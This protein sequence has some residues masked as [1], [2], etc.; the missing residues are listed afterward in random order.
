MKPLAIAGVVLIGLGLA[1][2]ILQSI[3]LTGSETIA[4]V[5]PLELERETEETIPLPPIA[6]GLAMV[7]GVALVIVGRK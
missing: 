4:E 1:I 6:G 7:A 2:L 3:T 5:G